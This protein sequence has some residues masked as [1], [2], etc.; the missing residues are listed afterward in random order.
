MLTTCRLFQ[1]QEELV[2]QYQPQTRAQPDGTS[3]RIELQSEAAEA[4][5][6]WQIQRLVFDVIGRQTNYLPY[7]VNN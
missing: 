2:K 6:E 4:Q 1:R 5:Y 7:L 3:P